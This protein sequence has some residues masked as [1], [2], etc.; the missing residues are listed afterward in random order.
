MDVNG[1]VWAGQTS[2]VF[3]AFDWQPAPHVCV[4]CRWMPMPAPSVL[5]L[6][7]LSGVS[8]AEGPGTKSPQFTSPC[9]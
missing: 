2:L 5:S 9:H 1:C 4:S 8:G 7:P 3:N 6:H